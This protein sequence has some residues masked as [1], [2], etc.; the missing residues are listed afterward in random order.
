MEKRFERSFLDDIIH[1]IVTPRRVEIQDTHGGCV[2]VNHQLG[3]EITNAIREGLY[4]MADN[5]EIGKAWY[6]ETDISL[7]SVDKKRHDR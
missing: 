6:G 5:P 7:P 1:V 4:E 2:V 3:L